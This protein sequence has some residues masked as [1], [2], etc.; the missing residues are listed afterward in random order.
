[1]NFDDKFTFDKFYASDAYHYLCDL[2][3]THLRKITLVDTHNTGLMGYNIGLEFGR[4]YDCPVM[5]CNDDTVFAKNWFLDL[6]PDYFNSDTT[7]FRHDTKEPVVLDSKKIGV[8]APCYVDPGCM[9]HQKYHPNIED[10]TAVD[11]C[12]GHAQFI[13]KD[14]VRAGFT[15]DPKICEVFGP[16][17]VYQSMWMQQHEFNILIAQ[18]CCFDFPNSKESHYHEGSKNFDFTAPWHVM[19]KRLMQEYQPKH[20]AKYGFNKW[21]FE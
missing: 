15:F 18:E 3:D 12:V 8:V 16:Y 1:M 20:I 11:F 19:D 6:N 10:Y 4:I 13:T 14:A 5:L 2:P 17:D 9:K 7:I 21:L